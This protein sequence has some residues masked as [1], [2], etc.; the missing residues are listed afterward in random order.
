MDRTRK[1]RRELSYGMSKLR[2]LEESVDAAD[3]DAGAKALATRIRQQ[4][5][6]CLDL[7]DQY[8]LAVPGRMWTYAETKCRP[9]RDDLKRTELLFRDAS[10]EFARRSE[11]RPYVH[12]T[13]DWMW[14]DAYESD[15]D[16]GGA[17]SGAA[18]GADSG[19][20]DEPLRTHEVSPVALSD[21]YFDAH[22]RQDLDGL[23]ELVDD[24]VEFKRAFDQ[25]LRG[26]TTVR[27]QYEK[28]W[29]D[30]KYEI[31]YVT[32]IFEADGK[33][34]IE[35]QVDS[36]PPSNLIYNGVVVHHW[37]DEGR[38]ARSQLYVD[39]VAPEEGSEG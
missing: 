17:E 18:S 4:A 35:I 5:G 15:E 34:A 12:Q 33:I 19:A 25:T 37:N 29:A 23:M 14:G 32:E 1:L 36:G 28:D 7:L 26:K 16:L 31:V 2:V 8:Q 39:E 20:D 11:V 22:N 3:D 6:V 27:E 9:L 30:H 13:P 24:D 21:R 38:L 10:G